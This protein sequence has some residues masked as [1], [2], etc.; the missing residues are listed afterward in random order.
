MLYRGLS[1]G[2]VDKEQLDE[3]LVLVPSPSLSKAELP[4]DVTAYGQVRWL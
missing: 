2:L 4:C 1:V 3:A